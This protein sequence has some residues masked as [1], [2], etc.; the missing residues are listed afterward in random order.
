MRGGVSYG[1]DHCLSKVIGGKWITINLFNFS[2]TLGFQGRG[3]V[4]LFGCLQVYKGEMWCFFFRVMVDGMKSLPNQASFTMMERLFYVSSFLNAAMMM[5]S[6]GT[7][8]KEKGV[9]SIKSAYFFSLK[10]VNLYAPSS[11]SRNASRS[12]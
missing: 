11:S 1:V 2:T 8:I 3:I 5:R 12:M 7:L 4:D 10:L 6:F 9:F